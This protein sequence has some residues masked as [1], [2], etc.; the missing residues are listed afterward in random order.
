MILRWYVLRSK[1]NKEEA[2]WRE[3]SARDQEVFYPRIHVQPVNPRSRKVRPYFPG[4]MFVNIDLSAVGPSA[5]TWM[6]HSYRLVTLGSEPSS[7]PEGLIHAL[8]RRVGEV[9]DSAGD[10][11]DGLKPGEEVTIQAGP[12]MGYEAL[13]DGRLPGSERARVLLKLLSKQQIPLELPAGQIERK[14]Q[15]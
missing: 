10:L 12:F 11:F 9:N 8:R 2:L 3:V 14:N 1:P 15:R 4:Y 13:F 5:F 7:V 6:P